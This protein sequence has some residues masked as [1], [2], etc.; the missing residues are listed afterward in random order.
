MIVK[1]VYV[2][3]FG[4]IISGAQSKEIF[5]LEW[6]TRQVK[7][8]VL[9]DGAKKMFHCIIICK[10]YYFLCEIKGINTK[11]IFRFYREK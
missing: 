8:V 2:F 1:V 7:S 10:H 5:I 6:R 9:S 11:W 4:G 3:L